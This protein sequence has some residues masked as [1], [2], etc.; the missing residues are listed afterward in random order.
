MSKRDY[1][2][3][4]PFHYRIIQVSNP[5]KF[6]TNVANSLQGGGR[7]AYMG[8]GPHGCGMVI[9]ETQTMGEIQPPPPGVESFIIGGVQEMKLGEAEDKLNALGALGYRFEG[10][11][12]YGNPGMYIILMTR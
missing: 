1:D 11:A 8:I 12:P 5:E 10:L 3:T 7:V 6:S 2:P 4:R 9:V